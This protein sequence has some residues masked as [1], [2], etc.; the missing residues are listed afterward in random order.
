MTAPEMFEAMA[1]KLAGVIDE[2]PT[3]EIKAGNGRAG[4]KS[5]ATKENKTMASKK[6]KVKPDLKVVGGKAEAAAP[7]PKPAEINPFDLES[8]VM[9]PAYKE[10]TGMVTS[11]ATLPV[12][13]KAG[14]QTFFMCHPDP[15]YSQILCVVKW[16]ESDD[17]SKGDWYVVH[18]NVARA[19]PD[20]PTFR[21]AKIYFCISQTGKEF[22]VVVPMPRDNDKG[23]WISSK[24]ACFE[25]ARS[26]FIKMNSN[27]AAGQWVYQYAMTDGPEPPPAWP[28]E[29]YISILK[30]GF[31][32]PRQD[33]YI[34]TMDHYVI[35]ALQGIR[36][37]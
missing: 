29:S 3:T 22:L 35:K 26:R 7:D 11:V 18:P 23:D 5:S 19:M 21:L 20:E 33:R 24:H 27:T 2:L 32:S 14:P 34:A 10:P 15:Q 28:T 4:S 37:C 6:S 30:R 13:D 25:A 31:K 9:V 12:Q 1:A 8:L 16:H 36:P 17:P